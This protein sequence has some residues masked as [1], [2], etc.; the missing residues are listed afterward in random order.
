MNTEKIAQHANQGAHPEPAVGY[1]EK[2]TS[3]LEQALF[4]FREGINFLQDQIKHAEE[5]L[6]ERL[7]DTFSVALSEELDFAAVPD[8]VNES[9]GEPLNVGSS[10]LTGSIINLSA[11][12]NYSIRSFQRLKAKIDFLEAHSELPTKD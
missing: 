5:T 1:Q 12:V 10:I 8:K 9:T 3:P 2:K 4:E 7:R 11:Q 6:P